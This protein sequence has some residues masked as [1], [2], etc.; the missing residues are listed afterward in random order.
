[1]ACVYCA[2][3]ILRVIIVVRDGSNNDNDDDK[4]EIAGDI[5]QEQ[6]GASSSERHD[7]H[8]SNFVHN[9]DKPWIRWTAQRCLALHIRSCLF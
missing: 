9:I 7:G 3:G 8:C 1:M 2:V 4:E 6:D 5:E